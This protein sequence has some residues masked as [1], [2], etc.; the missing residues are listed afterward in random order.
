VHR[1]T[2]LLNQALGTEQQLP[3]RQPAN[4]EAV[5][6]TCPSL[7]FVI[8]GSERPINR[9]KDKDKQKDS[10][11]GKTKTHSVKNNIITE[12]GG[13]VM[14]LSGTHAGKKHDKKYSG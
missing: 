12:R 14:Y 10:Y 4:L 3:E 11:S 6:S 5:L 7:E 1:L 8:D 9:P 13:K 2:A